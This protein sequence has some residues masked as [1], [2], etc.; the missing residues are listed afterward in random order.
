MTML[1]LFSMSGSVALAAIAL[2][3]A[4]VVSVFFGPLQSTFVC[5]TVDSDM[6]GRAMGLLGM[7]IGALP[8]GTFLLGEIA[9]R[10]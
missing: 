8:I 9:E 2:F 7:A 5:P 3:I 4:A 6:R 1:V 10:L